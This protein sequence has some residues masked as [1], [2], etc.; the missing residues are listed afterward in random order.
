MWLPFV[1]ACFVLLAH[2]ERFVVHYQSSAAVAN[3]KKMDFVIVERQTYGVNVTRS[4]IDDAIAVW[5][6]ACTEVAPLVEWLKSRADVVHV[7]CEQ[8]MYHL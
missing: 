7:D 6:V 5:E 3:D 8:A 1:I 2:G 4:P